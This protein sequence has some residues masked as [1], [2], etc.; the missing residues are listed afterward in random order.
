MVAGS[1][2]GYA[3]VHA[4]IRAL[5]ATLLSPMDLSRLAEAPDL[6]YLLRSLKDTVYGPYLTEV[7]GQAVTPRQIVYQIPEC[8]R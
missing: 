7:E 8:S 2:A 4:R 1:V 5:Y 6:R 3:A